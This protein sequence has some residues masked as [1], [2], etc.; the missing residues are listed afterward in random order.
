[1]SAGC[2]HQ[3]ASVI[4][5]GGFLAGSFFFGS[6]IEYAAGALVGILVGPDLDVDGGYIGNTIIRNRVGR[7][8]EVGYN[9]LWY[10]YKKSLKHGSPLS[11]W[12]VVSSVFRLA[13]L[14]LFLLVFPYSL[15][16]LVVPGAWNIRMEIHWWLVLLSRHYQIIL[17]L[18]GSDLIH[19]VLDVLTTE[20]AKQKQKMEIFGMPL[21]SS[22]CK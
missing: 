1:V 12:P 15:M 8:A 9:M 18:I 13:Y 7:W 4:L 17:G 22:V 19:W 10:P 6:G 21:A 2:V 14:F 20:H 3:K 16:E 5:A 11:H